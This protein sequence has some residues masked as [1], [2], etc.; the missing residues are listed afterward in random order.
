MTLIFILI[1]L[2]AC[3]FLYSKNTKNQMEARKK[4]LTLARENNELKSK[5]S[6]EKALDLIYFKP[7][8]ENADVKEGVE[9]KQAPL[10]SSPSNMTV[11]SATNV[12]VTSGAKINGIEWFFIEGNNFS[13]WIKKE[14]TIIS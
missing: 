10:N 8:S 2:L 13:G 5:F 11:E 4:I 6:K 9:V 7:S 3:T 12:K 1:L 14:D